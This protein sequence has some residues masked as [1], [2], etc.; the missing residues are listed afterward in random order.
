MGYRDI[1][2]TGVTRDKRDTG[3]LGDIEEIRK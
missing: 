3:V 2:D 1:G